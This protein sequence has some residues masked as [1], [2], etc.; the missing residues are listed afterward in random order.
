MCMMYRYIKREFA[1]CSINMTSISIGLFLV[2]VCYFKNKVASF[3]NCH[4]TGNTW[5]IRWMQYN[6]HYSNLR[7]LFYAFAICYI[8]TN[9]KVQLKMESGK[10]RVH[11]YHEP[12]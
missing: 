12:L 6:V 8:Q 5:K 4:K 1:I 10:K 7:Q 3:Y 2:I 11:R 9:Q